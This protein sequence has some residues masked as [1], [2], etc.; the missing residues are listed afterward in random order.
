[1][2]LPASCLAL[3]PARLPFGGGFYLRFLPL[4]LTRAAIRHTL[5]QDRPVVFYVHPWELDPAQPR[6]KLPPRSPR[7]ATTVS[8]A[9]P[10]S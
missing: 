7:R 4:A 8:A 6:L 10:G 9:R 5:R 3:G 1:M 2:E